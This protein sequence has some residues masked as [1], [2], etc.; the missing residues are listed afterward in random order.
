MLRRADGWLMDVFYPERTAC[1]TCGRPSRGARL[2]PGFA[3]ELNALR[4][5]GERKLWLGAAY[6]YQGVARK[7]VHRLKYDCV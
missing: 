1:L 5:Y 6:R 3:A 7:L 2:C 4:L